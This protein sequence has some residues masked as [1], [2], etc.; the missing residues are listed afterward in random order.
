MIKAL[1]QYSLRPVSTRVDPEI[2]KT[3]EA[4]ELKGAC[5]QFES[6]LW[7]KLWK[8]MRN[9]AQAISGSDQGRPWKQMED[10]SL[11]MAS[12]DLVESSGGAGLWRMLYDSMIG[13]VA[14]DR[15][16]RQRREA[17]AAA[18]AAFDAFNNAPGESEAGPAFEASA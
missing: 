10:L 12:D 6:I 5:Q 13:K 4:Q 9:S 17:D 15:E 2:H 1:D 16:A 3:K 11:E 8:D 18:D 7:A 14:A